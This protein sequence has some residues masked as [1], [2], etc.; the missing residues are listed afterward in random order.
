LDFWNAY[1][2]ECECDVQETAE[3]KWFQENKSLYYH[4]V[5]LVFLEWKF[6]KHI[7]ILNSEGENAKCDLMVSVACS[8]VH[9]TT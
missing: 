3:V 2:Q 9:G 8:A 6:E 1:P 7:F 5:M 4:N